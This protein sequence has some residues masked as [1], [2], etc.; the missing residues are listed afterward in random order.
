MLHNHID[1]E[2]FRCFCR[3]LTY[4]RTIAISFNLSSIYDMIT[5]SS[6]LLRRLIIKIIDLMQ[7]DIPYQ[8]GGTVITERYPPFDMISA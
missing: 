1:D 4:P 8:V 5:S 6:P 7:L 3:C 2:A